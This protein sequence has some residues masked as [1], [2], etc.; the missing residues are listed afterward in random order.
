LSS[1]LICISIYILPCYKTLLLFK[2]VSH[3]RGRGTR[4]QGYAHLKEQKGEQWFGGDS[5]MKEK[6]Q[7]VL[8]GIESATQLI[9]GIPFSLASK[10]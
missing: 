6:L 2:K 10:L 3:Q 5:R 9:M 8:P 7:A 4:Q 1:I